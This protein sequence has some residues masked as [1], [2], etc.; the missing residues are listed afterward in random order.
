MMAAV[1]V[2]EDVEGVEVKVV[3]EEEGEAVGHFLL[4][5]RVSPR[6]SKT[7]S[8]SIRDRVSKYS[9]LSS[10]GVVCSLL[11]PTSLSLTAIRIQLCLTTWLQHLHSTLSNLPPKHPELLSLAAVVLQ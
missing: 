9:T 3:V 6:A 7:L 8:L 10:L 11:P 2:V 4:K 5:A 1:E